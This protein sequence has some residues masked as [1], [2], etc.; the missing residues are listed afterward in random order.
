MDGGLVTAFRTGSAGGVSSQ[1]LAREDSQ[2]VGVIGAW[3]E[4]RM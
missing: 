3:E 4:A 1:V 2:M